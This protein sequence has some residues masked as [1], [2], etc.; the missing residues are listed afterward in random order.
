MQ[1]NS[2]QFKQ[3]VK[4]TVADWWGLITL[5]FLLSVIS[6][7]SLKI[8]TAILG[9][10]NFS[11]SLSLKDN[12]FRTL[13]ATW[14]DYRG[15]G[16]PSD[17]EVVD[18]FRQIILLPLDLLLPI[19]L[20]DQ[21]YYLALYVT[22]G[23][24]AFL[25]VK[26]VL[27]QLSASSRQNNQ[28]LQAAS[29][30]GALFYT[31]SLYTVDVFYL[32]IVMYLVRFAFFPVILLL[33]LKLLDNRH[34]ERRH[35]ILF[36]LVV[37][38][39][40]PSY[41]T[42]TVFFTLVILFFTL[43]FSYPHR[44]KRFASIFLLFFMLNLFWLLP[45]VNYTN[46]KAGTITQSSTFALVNEYLFN[47]FAERFSWDKL[48]T[49]S[50]EFASGLPFTSISTGEPV[51]VHESLEYTHIGKQVA[52]YFFLPLPFVGLGFLYLIRRLLQ[53][54]FE[55]LW[56]VVLAAGSMFLLRK[57]Y[58]PFGYIYDLLGEKI[59]PLKLVLRFGTT[60]LNPLLLIAFAVMV[61][62]GVYVLLQSVKWF[63]DRYLQAAPKGAILLAKSVSLIVLIV[64]L[65]WMA[66]FPLKGSMLFSLLRVSFP[67]EYYSVATTI[68]NDHSYAR[69]LHLPVGQFSYWRSYKWGYYGSSFFNFILNKPLLDKTFS[70]ANQDNDFFDFALNSV[71]QNAYA[72]DEA[73]INSRAKWLGELLRRAGVKYVLFDE[74]VDSN[75]AAKDVRTWEYIQQVEVKQMLDTLVDQEDLEIIQT[76]TINLSRH[77]R[78]YGVNISKIDEQVAANPNLVLYEV[79]NT[80][81]AVEVVDSAINLDPT[82]ANAFIKPLFTSQG[83]VIQTTAYPYRTYP[84]HNPLTKYSF[85]DEEITAVFENSGTEFDKI[86][87][88][89]ERRANS[90]FAVS[91]Y[92]RPRVD[93]LDIFGTL[94]KPV[95]GQSLSDEVLLFSLEIS[96]AEF[97]DLEAENITYNQVLANWHMLGN[98]QLS[99]YR[100]QIG[101]TILPLPAGFLSNPQ[102]LGSVLVNPG[103]T[104]V[105]LLEKSSDLISITPPAFRLTDDS[106]CLLDATEGYNPQ[107]TVNPNRLSLTTEK[108]SACI[109]KTIVIP[110]A[111]RYVEVEVSATQNSFGKADLDQ[112]F[113]P[114]QT[115]KAIERVVNSLPN[116]QSFGICIKNDVDGD[117]L[118]SRLS[119]NGN[120]PLQNVRVTSEKTFSGN[121]LQTIL[122][123]PTIENST[124]EL[125]VTK[126]MVHEYQPKYEA[127]IS[128]Y[129][130]ETAETFD[131]LA[132]QTNSIRF[133][134][135]FSPSSFYMNPNLD[136]LEPRERGVCSLAV[137]DHRDSSIRMIKSSIHGGLLSYLSD[138]YQSIFVSLPYI[139]QAFYLWTTDYHVYTGGQPQFIASEPY[140][141]VNEY[142]S[143]LDGY[144]NLPGF[145]SLQK[146]DPLLFRTEGFYDQMVQDALENRQLI[147]GQR[148]LISQ[149]PIQTGSKEYFEVHH[150][151]AN[152]AL[153]EFASNNVIAL[154]SDW[155]NTYLENGES[156]LNFASG[157]IT[158]IRKILPSLWQFSVERDQPS[159]GEMLLAFGQAYDT[160]WRLYKTDNILNVLWGRGLVA[161]QH[162]KVNGWSNGWIVSGQEISDEEPVVFYA[163]YLPERLA[164]AGW[165][166]SG[167][168]LLATIVYSK[169]RKPIIRSPYK[170]N[171]MRKVRRSLLG[172]I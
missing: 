86:S 16:V 90:P 166:I 29:L 19:R 146:A 15:F 163:F 20:V 74:S 7:I 70:P 112:S 162:V 116:Y 142:V 27:E 28:L 24:A 120:R 125:D 73:E 79:K 150:T 167:L 75:I 35:L 110:D 33:F 118:N 99:P 23:A 131:T 18:I 139:S 83:T 36:S 153:V 85:G 51:K 133:A 100:L 121:V 152:Q 164:I 45:F 96:A 157:Q 53:R 69:V 168:S 50:S 113:T 91:I 54:K 80:V 1:L 123:L 107:L 48:L 72:V 145:K 14:R 93:G 97:D 3:M 47:Q 172:R 49:F 66:Y 60:K 128:A 41:L 158:H 67:Q 165:F 137:G 77:A 26:E 9:W 44:L 8:D 21:V 88:G 58:P 32:P 108:G 81:D 92:S 159:D 136:A 31:F 103:I 109:A 71:F 169:S 124:H 154:P 155:Q 171:R 106:N 38:L 17:S 160:Q 122:I 138:C 4:K 57:E 65:G 89:Q 148:M 64:W 84:F 13:F 127:S 156:R 149:G 42:A 25:L 43:L 52:W 62:A 11:V 6:I 140:Q 22:G 68:N 135:V 98:K 129:Y 63:R 55:A 119:L 117:C 10:D 39:G 87:Y 151:V 76:E 161:G 94:A 37:F 102:F 82:F 61:G 78:V 111:A 59:P 30:A 104:N 5:L 95:I 40:A 56:P 170:R 115:Q 144:P 141:L 126:L 143:Y 114:S 147:R 134:P 2:T 132:D 34:W 12:F 130:S 46:H 101:E 105:A